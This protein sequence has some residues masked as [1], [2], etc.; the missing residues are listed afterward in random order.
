MKE[1]SGMILFCPS[2]VEE[3]INLNMHNSAIHQY[4]ISVCEIGLLHTG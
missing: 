2:F 1:L 4:L 3:H